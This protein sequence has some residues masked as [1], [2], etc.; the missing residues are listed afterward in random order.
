MEINNNK[1]DELLPRVK[2]TELEILSV[3]DAFCRKN[4]IKS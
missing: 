1:I 3:V 2:E 4:N